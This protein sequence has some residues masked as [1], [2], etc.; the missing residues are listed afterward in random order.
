MFKSLLTVAISGMLV[1]SSQ[2]A[3]AVEKL[4]VGNARIVVRTVTGTIEADLRRLHLA[5][6]IYHNELIETKEN[7]ATELIFLDDTKLAIGPNSSLTLNQIVYDPD[8]DRA[9]FVVT[10]TIGVFR[11]ISGKLP[12]TSYTI[13]TPTAT[14]GVRGTVLTIVAIPV[15]LSVDEFAVNITVEE[16]VAEVADCRGHRVVLDRSSLST[17]VSGRTGGTCSAPTSPGPQP[18][19][20]ASHVV[21]LYS[22]LVST[23][24]PPN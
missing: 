8:P 12:K 13:H 23:A 11:F 10:A 5:D 15:D 3:N 16:G 20:F 4:T 19:V 24:S 18:A 21:D 1:I 7:S 14:I 2:A 6:D 17:T 22:L 9:S